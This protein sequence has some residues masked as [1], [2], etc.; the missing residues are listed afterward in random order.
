MAAYASAELLAAQILDKPL[1]TDAAES[2]PTRYQDAA[3]LPRLLNAATFG[4]L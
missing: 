4:Q 1:P 2:T 3:Y